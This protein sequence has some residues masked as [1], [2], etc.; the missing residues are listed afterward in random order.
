MI[1]HSA[2]RIIA[3]LRDLPEAGLVANDTPI[4]PEIYFT[5]DAE[6]AD[7]SVAMTTK[8]GHL[9]DADVA[10]S[11]QPRWLSLNIGLG[12]GTLDRGDQLVVVLDFA[13]EMADEFK[14]VLMSFLDGNRSDTPLEEPLAGGP[15]GCVRTVL[16]H[17]LEE[18]AQAGEAAF[19]T[20]A[21][22][23]PATDH[24]VSLRDL[25]ITVVPRT[26]GVRSSP[27]TLSDLA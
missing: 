9:L 24:R 7:V 27:R 14:L 26:R 5:W 6:Q 25:R 20:L 11:G 17:I 12:V 23:L 4:V 3:A 15:T 21:I 18:D 8:S 10:V 22:G 13:A 2:D 16:H 19:H 1:D